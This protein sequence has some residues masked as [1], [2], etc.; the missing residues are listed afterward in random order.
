LNGNE[1]VEEWPFPG[2]VH[3]ITG[4]NP[5]GI[6]RQGDDINRMIAADV[7]AEGGQFVLGEGTSLDGLHSERS[8]VV[9]GITRE[10]AAELGRRASQDA[11]FEIDDRTVRVVACGSD[12]I[13]EIGPR[14][15]E[16]TGS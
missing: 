3:V 4:W 12:R 13:D 11:V 14:R 7:L 15:G 16:E 2:P 8:L 1:A 6:A 10:F 5:Q 9:W